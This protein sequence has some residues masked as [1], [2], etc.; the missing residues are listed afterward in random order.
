MK[1][2]NI[3]GQRIKLLRTSYKITQEQL[4][5]ELGLNN[6]SSIANYESGYSMPSDE[7]KI[8][9]AEYFCVSLDYLLGKTD[10]PNNSPDMK[11]DHIDIIEKEQDLLDLAKIG[12]NKDNYNPPTEKQKEQ[13]R[14]LLEV[15]LKDNKKDN[16]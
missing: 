12:F 5:K 10:I 2:N 9:L 11:N 7:I 8:K 6:K 1:S 14:D 16:K 15:I 3:T 4:A 13:I